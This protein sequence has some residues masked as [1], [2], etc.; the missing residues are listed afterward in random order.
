MN[1]NTKARRKDMS[2]KN[3]IERLLEVNPEAEIW[4]DSSPIIYENWRKKILDRAQN[5][6][7][8]KIWLNRLFHEER[9]PTENIFRGVTTNPPL[10]HDAI[11]DNPEQWG[12]WLKERFKNRGQV[13]PEAAFWETYKEIVKK[14]AEVYM[15][16]F[17]TSG[18][19]H[20]FI[21]G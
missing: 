10:S 19:R 21:S 16:L 15:P 12:R 17:E 4:W 5:K 2:E 14:G 9:H 6:E 8:M 20:G 1:Q 3:A 11:K 7:Q 13:D 18:Y